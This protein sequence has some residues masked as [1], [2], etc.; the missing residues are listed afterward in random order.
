MG[1][2]EIRLLII[3]LLYLALATTLDL[4]LD[5]WQRGQGKAWIGLI[6]YQALSMLLAFLLLLG[7]FEA[8]WTWQFQ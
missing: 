1:V 8:A 4:A 2:G 3:L 5:C 6:V 7:F